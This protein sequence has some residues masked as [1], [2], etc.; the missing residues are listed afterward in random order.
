MNLA[1]IMRYKPYSGIEIWG[2]PFVLVL[3]IAKQLG[4]QNLAELGWVKKLSN[5]LCSGNHAVNFNICSVLHSTLVHTNH[6]IY[7]FHIGNQWRKGPWFWAF[8]WN[9]FVASSICSGCEL[10][11]RHG[12]LMNSTEDAMMRGRWCKPC[13]VDGVGAVVPEMK[14]V[15]PTTEQPDTQVISFWD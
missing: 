4:R 2:L 13:I 9:N 11:V 5:H 14:L 15:R 10:N 3:L 8:L 1:R 12:G 6:F 7:K